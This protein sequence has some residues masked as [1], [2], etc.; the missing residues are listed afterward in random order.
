VQRPGGYGIVVNAT[1]LGMNDADPL[2]RL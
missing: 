1:P 2:A